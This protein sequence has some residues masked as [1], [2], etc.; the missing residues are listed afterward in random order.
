M[1]YT[2]LMAWF[3]LHCP[4]I[5]QPGEELPKGVLFA[6]LHRF[7]GSQWLRTYIAG[8]RKLVCCYDMYNLYRCF[9]SIPGAEYGEEFQNIGD[10]RS[11]LGKGIFKWLVGIRPL[12][13]CIGVGISAT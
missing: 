6:H 12:T 10:G 1:P 2:Y 3:M 7:E 8:V 5:L 9:P 4:A 13:W 11:L